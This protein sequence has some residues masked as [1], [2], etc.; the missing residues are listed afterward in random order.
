MLPPRLVKSWPTVQL[1]MLIALG[2]CPCTLPVIETPL[3]VHVAPAGM[4]MF[5]LTVDPLAGAFEPLQVHDPCEDAVL[6]HSG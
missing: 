4:V 1:V 3:T 6:E 2:L 5:P